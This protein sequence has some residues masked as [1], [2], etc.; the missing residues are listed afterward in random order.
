MF[1]HVP[2]H[3]H[4]MHLLN[5][6]ICR[7]THVIPTVISCDQ[8]R[9]VMKLFIL[10][11]DYTVFKVRCISNKIWTQITPFFICSPG[12]VGQSVGH[13]THNSEV[14]GSIPGLATYFH[15]SFPDSRG[16]VVTYWR[17]YVHEVLVNH[18]RGLS[19]PRKKCG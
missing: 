3:I 2:S 5:S 8:D 4:W 1:N 18:L 15:F 7:Y 14:L 11:M 19:L 17:K 16:A 10:E 9:Y 6:R 12:R 13:L